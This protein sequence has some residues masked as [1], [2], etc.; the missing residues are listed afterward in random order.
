MPNIRKHVF[1]TLDN[2]ALTG[3]YPTLTVAVLSL[4]FPVKGMHGKQKM[5]HNQPICSFCCK[6]WS[7]F[8]CDTDFYKSNIYKIYQLIPLRLAS[9]KQPRETLHQV[10][11]ANQVS[12]LRAL[13]FL[14]DRVF[15]PVLVAV[16]F[17][18]FPPG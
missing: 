10:F 6:Q 8:Q 14:V 9:R 5:Q 4:V 1:I 11:R 18:G 15:G 7:K 16:F 3:E 13:R 2:V 12:L 17:I